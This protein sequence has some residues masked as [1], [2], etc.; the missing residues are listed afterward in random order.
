MNDADS[1]N[2]STYIKDKFMKHNIVSFENHFTPKRKLYSKIS[3]RKGMNLYS[4]VKG[5]RNIANECFIFTYNRRN[6]L[7]TIVALSL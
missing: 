2:A 6:T 4:I 5:R 1:E 3:D 7:E